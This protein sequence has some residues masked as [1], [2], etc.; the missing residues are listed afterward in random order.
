MNLLVSTVFV[1]GML[2]FF[3]PCV[4]PL[5]PVYIGVITDRV[6]GGKEFHIGNKTFALAPIIKTLLFVGGL[7]TIFIILGFGAGAL[8]GIINTSYFNIIAGIIVILLGLH[9]MEI[10]R[11]K[12][13][14]GT[15]KLRFN[16]GKYNPY[17]GAYVLGLTFSFGW[18][19]CVGPVLGA[20]LFV[21][22]SGGQAL[23]GG[24][25]MT[26]YSLGLAMPFLIIAMLSSVLL[27]RF[28]RLE[29]HL[30]KIKKVGGFLIVIMGGLLM[31]DKLNMITV[32][33][34]KLFN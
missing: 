18:T 34:E 24:F 17:M 30:G 23:Y 1:A 11:F 25:M 19:P 3:A 13:L 16:Q 2:S 22:A 28:E 26:V 32:Y 7:S 5:L 31:T 20:I 4:F 33:I 14:E 12:K 10:I 9:Q 8:G 27:E 15:K 29:K 6:E 21:A